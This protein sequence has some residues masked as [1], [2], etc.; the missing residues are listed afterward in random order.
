MSFQ[1][2]TK[3]SKS[4]GGIDMVTFQKNINLLLREQRKNN[5]A[6]KIETIEKQ[7]K[8]TSENLT[9]VNNTLELLENIVLNVGKKVHEK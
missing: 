5:N 6:N 8:K 9:E 7:C 2:Y 3:S 4:N 1:P